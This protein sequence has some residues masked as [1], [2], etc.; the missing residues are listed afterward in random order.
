MS[1]Q[2]VILFHPLSI[3]QVLH[4]SVVAQSPDNHSPTDV[5]LSTSSTI[6]QS[7]HSFNTMTKHKPDLSSEPCLSTNV[8]QEVR[9]QPAFLTCTVSESGSDAR[10]LSAS[11]TP[12]LSIQGQNCGKTSC[13][14]F[15]REGSNGAT[16]AIQPFKTVPA[17]TNRWKRALKTE[18][19]NCDRVSSKDRPTPQIIESAAELGARTLKGVCTSESCLSPVKRS[20]GYC[21]ST[22]IKYMQTDI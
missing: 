15:E 20:P 10:Q 22:P 1:V 7:G 14:Q 11:Q 4:E 17:S 3:V 2:V 18:E 9:R 8:K 6:T 19:G 5:K 13:E 16:E 12:Q 21:P